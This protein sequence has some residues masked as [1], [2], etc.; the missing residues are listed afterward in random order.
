M[1]EY[2]GYTENAN[3]DLACQEALE[4]IQDKNYAHNYPKKVSFVGY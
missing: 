3:F 2:Y 1:L 4:Q